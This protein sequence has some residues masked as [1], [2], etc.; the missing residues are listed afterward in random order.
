MKIG[1]RFQVK[2]KDGHLKVVFDNW[3]FD[4]E[5]HAI[6]DSRIRTFV[7]PGP[8]SFS[9]RIRSTNPSTGERKYPIKGAGAHGSVDPPGHH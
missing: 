9:C 7:T 3:P 2:S 8:F 5:K 4:G 1:D 6:T